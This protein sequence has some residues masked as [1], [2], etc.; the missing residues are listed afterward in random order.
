MSASKHGIRTPEEEAESSA[1]YR[2]AEDAEWKVIQ[3]NTF[4]RW[5]NERLKVRLYF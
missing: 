1:K 5:I 4:T 3:K 2:L